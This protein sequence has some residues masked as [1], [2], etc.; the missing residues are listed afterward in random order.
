[1]ALCAVAVVSSLIFGGAALALKLRDV[2]A[3]GAVGLACVVS[4]LIGRPLLVL[5]T[6]WV[7]R[8]D[9][10]ASARLRGR[11]TD[12]RYVRNLGVATGLAGV[13]LRRSAR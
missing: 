4:A 13:Y 10:A 3:L 8:S 5:T 2:A 1:V 6:R 12:R 9:F 11:L 7:V